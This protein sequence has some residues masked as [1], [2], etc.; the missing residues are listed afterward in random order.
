MANVRSARTPSSTSAIAVSSAPAKKFALT[1]I[2]TKSETLPNRYGFHAGVGFGKTSLAACS[3]SPIFVQTRGETGL[4]A[5]IQSGQLPEV[6]HF[7][8]LQ[9]WTDLLAALHFL[10]TEEHAF[11]TLVLDTG[12]G[13]ERMM[14]EFVCD[15]DFGGDWT[16]TGFMGY[17]RGYEVSLADW[18]M[19]LNALDELRKQKGMT[20]FLLFHSRIKTFKNP[21]GA[22]YDRYVPEMHDKTWGL[23]KGWLDCILF[24]NFEV[25]VMAGGKEAQ[26]GRKGKAAEA[27]ARIIYTHSDNPTFDAKNR[28]GLPEEIE[29]GSSAKEGWDNLTKAVK[30]GRKVEGKA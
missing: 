30:E 16:E 7:P 24:G 14:H 5:L 4:D 29:M 12:N 13:A 28:L 15:R 9:T 26:P 27:S 17:M 2:V 25:T 10:K 22:D 11:K 6:P 23:T 20:I 3:L 19:F 18:R 21:S 1:D 8:E